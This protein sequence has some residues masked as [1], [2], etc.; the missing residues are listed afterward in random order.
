MILFLDDWKSYPGA[1]ADTTTTNESFL[2]YVKT[3]KAMGVRNHAFCL[4]LHQPAL[5]GVDPFDE[6]LSNEQRAM[7][8]QEAKHN[9][10][11]FIRE[12]ARVPQVGT[13]IPSPYL[14]NRANIAL[15]WCFLNNIDF[16]N[17]MPR[18]CGKSVGADILNNWLVQLAGNALNIQLLTR[19]D[20]LR[21]K[22]IKRLKAIRD[23]LPPYI[24]Y[25]QKGVDK[26]NTEMLTCVA[27]GNEYTAAVAQKDKAAAD[28]TGRGLTSSIIQ[29]DEAPYCANI[30]ISLPVALGGTGTARD[31]A[32]ANGTFYG[33]L[34]TTTAGKLDTPEG[35]FMYELIHSGMYWNERLFDA[36]CRE[37]AWDIVIKHSSKG[38][39]LVNGTF[40]HL[41]I[42]K[43]NEWLRGKIIDSTSDKD[44]AERDYLNI[45]TSGSESSPLSITLNKIIRDSSR[46]P[47]YTQLCP[48][49]YCLNWYI[50]QDQL[51]QRLMGT[52]LALCVDPS[53]SVGQDGNGMVIVD[54]RNMEVVAA[55]DITEAN[56]Y[57]YAI[58][59]AD[60]LI[61]FPNMVGVVEN[62]AS[63]QSIID[64]M[65]THLMSNGHDPFR[66]MFNRVI[67][68]SERGPG[69]VDVKRN[70]ERL[71]EELYVRYKGK[72]GFNTTGQSRPVLYGMVLQRAAGTSGHLVND[73]CLADQLLKLVKKNGRVDHPSG[74]HDDAVI[75]WL[76]G[77]WFANHARELE[78]YGIKPGLVQ[79]LVSENGAVLSPEQLAEKGRQATIIKRI[80][81][82]KDRLLAAD[83]NVLRNALETQIRTMVRGIGDTDSEVKIMD[84][85]LKELK[86]QRAQKN[87]LCNALQ[88]HRSMRR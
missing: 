63:G 29:L 78:W 86:E 35:S 9:Y 72:F 22:N 50:P 44:A 55:S 24:N 70:S 8:A 83:N 15:G 52:N 28:N 57:K 80:E 77:H 23:L 12:V 10:W 26:N 45:W 88:R 14:A 79:S 38:R 17:I 4:S 54:L 64:I 75:A 43:S 21:V 42:G 53:N 68:E 87:S 36:R 69:Y 58:W 61:M 25:Y 76:L 60:L 41:Q 3:L 18:Q 47:T 40:S 27:L 20:D 46:E 67:D 65:A 33:N 62:K 85:L 7:V 5:Q 81:A 66:R 13:H 49:N 51:E 37:D 39:R 31:I 30:H 59:L 84:D 56:I 11:Y 82:L 2:V 6:N 73:K 71:E 48:N 32:E 74:G 19:G 1:I 34:Y 16:A